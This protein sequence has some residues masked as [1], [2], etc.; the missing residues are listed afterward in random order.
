MSTGAKSITAGPKK[1]LAGILTII[2]LLIVI[3]SIGPVMGAIESLTHV[4]SQFLNA[5]TGI[6]GQVSQAFSSAAGGAR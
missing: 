6:L 1:V 3:K 4:V 5:V 2:V